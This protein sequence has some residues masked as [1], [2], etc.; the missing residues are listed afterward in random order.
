[1]KRVERASVQR[2]W[3]DR[4]EQLCAPLVAGLTADCHCKAVCAN[5]HQLYAAIE[6]THSTN[7]IEHYNFCLVAVSISVPPMKSHHCDAIKKL[8]IINVYEH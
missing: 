2:L 5:L 7:T 4:L 6:F 3:Q 8:I 1:M